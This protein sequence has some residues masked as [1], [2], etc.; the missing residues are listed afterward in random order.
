MNRGSNILPILFCVF[1]LSVLGWC[2]AQD[3]R[4]AGY[5]E[6]SESPIIEGVS[7]LFSLPG[8]ILGTAVKNGGLEVAAFGTA[9]EK[10]AFAK[11]R[12][13]RFGQMPFDADEDL[14]NRG[15]SEIRIHELGHRYG[16]SNLWP[17]ARN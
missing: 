8:R 15:W 12:P 17:S 13:T 7:S 5:S 16:F 11:G 2:I 1:A 10:H 3:L 9:A 6:A 14:Q 4:P